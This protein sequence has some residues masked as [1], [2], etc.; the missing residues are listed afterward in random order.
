VQVG[1]RERSSR[2]DALPARDLGGDLRVLRA[3]R[4]LPRLLGLA[5]LDAMPA[6]VALHFPRCRS[7]HTLGMRFPL[8]LIWL[9]ADGRPVRIDREVPPRRFKACRRAR[10]VVEAN[11]GTADDFLAHGL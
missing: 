2:L 8:D 6:G 1:T 5:G 7:V 3:D 11:A 10:S 4:P 9:G